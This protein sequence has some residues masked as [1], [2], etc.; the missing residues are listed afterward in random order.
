[1]ER[2]TVSKN[3]E[4]GAIIS[5]LFG[6]L[7]ISFFVIPHFLPYQGNTVGLMILFLS[8]TYLPVFVVFIILS[9]MPIIG[10]LFGIKSRTSSKR[11]LAIIGIILNVIS[12][13]GVLFFYI[14]QVWI[15]CSYGP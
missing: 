3:K 11:I 8:A 15:R 13:L 10:S 7:S 1:M 9:L 14:F 6:I 2:E 12:L 4:R 5:L